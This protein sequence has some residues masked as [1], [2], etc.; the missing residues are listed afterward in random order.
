ML[1]A[2]ER[3]TRETRFYTDV[4][5]ISD[6]VMQALSKVNRAQFVPEYAIAVSY[7]H[8]RAHET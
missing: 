4:E 3:T 6:H 8:L 2:I 7:T 1:V 5:T